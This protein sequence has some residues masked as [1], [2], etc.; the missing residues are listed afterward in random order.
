[1]ASAL[2]GAS[3]FPALAEGQ[4][5]G[6]EA[7]SRQGQREKEGGKDGLRPSPCSGIPGQ[8]G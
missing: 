2:R 6:L 5:S 1:M 3:H 8:P 7:E 4:S